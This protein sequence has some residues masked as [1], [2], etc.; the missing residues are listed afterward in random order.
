MTLKPNLFNKDEE[1][2]KQKKTRKA[3]DAKQRKTKETSIMKSFERKGKLQA[4]TLISCAPNKS[5]LI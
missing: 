3:Y 2:I 4:R 5:H 1:K